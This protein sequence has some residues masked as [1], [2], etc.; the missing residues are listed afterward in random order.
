MHKNA[1][2][3]NAHILV[4]DLCKS[5]ISYEYLR[6]IG[7]TNPNIHVTADLAFAIDAATD[8]RVAEILQVEG[9]SGVR[10]PIIGVSLSKVISKWAF[11]D[12]SDPEEKYKRYVKIIAS[13]LDDLIVKTGGTIVFIPHVFGSSDSNNDR[14]THK[15]INDSMKLKDQTLLIDTEYSAGE[16]RGL[17]GNCDFFIGA[18]THAL[19]SAA[20][21]CV[22]FIGLE[23]ESFKTRG[24]LGRMLGFDRYVYNIQEMDEGSLKRLILD[25][26]D[27]KSSIRQELEQKLPG[28]RERVSIN[29]RLL[30]E[31]LDKK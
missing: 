16:L 20:M 3:C 23:Y 4:I 15:K 26:W 31:L 2:G 30:H 5:H 19:I 24:I 14:Q 22:P 12:V 7:V 29:D 27:Q 17:I 1:N 13:I 6:K 8:K 25:C 9:V 11:P 21:T 10:K 18:R 28:I